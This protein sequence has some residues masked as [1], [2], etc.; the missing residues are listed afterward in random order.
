MPTNIPPEAWAKFEEYRRA[1]TPEEKL[2]KLQEFMALMPKH[3]GTE[4]MEKF[5]RRKMAELREEIERRRARKARRGGPGIF[6]EKKG[7]AQVVLLGFTNSGRSTVLSVLTNARPEISPAPFTTVGRPEEGMMEFKGAQVHFVEAPPVLREGGHLTR[8]ALG[9]AGNADAIGFV[10]DGSGDPVGD[11]RDLLTIVESA[12]IKV[13]RPEGRVRI[14]RSRGVDSVIVRRRGVIVDGT[15]ADVR[16]LLESYGMDRVIV[17][18]DG[19]V[20]LSDVEEALLGE[21]RYKPAL[22]FVTRCDLTTEGLERVREEFGRVMPVVPISARE[23]PDREELGELV[24]RLTGVMRIFT[25]PVGRKE[26]SER[27]LILERGST[28]ADAARAIHEHL[29]R[30]FRYAKVWSSRLPYSP[31]RV[32]A[33]FELEDGDVIEIHA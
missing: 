24:L 33:D 12:G 2:R 27:A 3:K 23:P 14:V 31:M 16:R 17:E 9:L 7:A 19:R 6:V 4:K 10:V 29:Y 22:V 8:L 5:L 26:P 32:G 25:K 1:K 15:E 13:G 21:K 18:I 11:L 30:R 28:V 20:R